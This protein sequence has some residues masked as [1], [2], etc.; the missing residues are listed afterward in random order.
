MRTR[1]S[2]RSQSVIASLLERDMFAR[3]SEPPPLARVLVKDLDEDI[4]LFRLLGRSKLR[5]A[6]NKQRKSVEQCKVAG[7]LVQ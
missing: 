5:E 2:F 6:E 3:S 7:Q 1:L 4:K